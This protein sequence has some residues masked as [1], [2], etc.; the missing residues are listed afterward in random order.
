MHPNSLANLHKWPKGT[1]GNPAGHKLLEQD[2]KDGV[3]SSSNL[4]GLVTLIESKWNLLCQEITRWSKL[5]GKQQ[6]LMTPQL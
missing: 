1:S 6:L 4:N 3:L 5:L 2:A